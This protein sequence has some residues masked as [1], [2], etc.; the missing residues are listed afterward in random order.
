MGSDG[1]FGGPRTVVTSV[2]LVLLL[3]AAAYADGAFQGTTDEP[4]P[5]P[6]P[7]VS[8]TAEPST[9]PGPT[10]PG[11][12]DPSPTA[13]PTAAPTTEPVPDGDE[14]AGGNPFARCAGLTGLENAICRVET[15]LE[16]HP[17][18][19]LERALERLQHNLARK[20]E[21]EAARD[22][23]EQPG[24]GHGGGSDRG[25][26]GGSDHG[27]GGGP[28]PWAGGGS[29]GQAGGSSNAGGSGQGNGRP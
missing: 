9:D 20:Q 3:G 28:P 25:N 1:S 15:N 26:G 6:T 7:T 23:R 4:V 16:R 5:G 27:N 10:D 18:P 14:E 13:T 19:G 8:P 24:N 29:A 2:V 12:T 17:T 21:R 11:P 22:A